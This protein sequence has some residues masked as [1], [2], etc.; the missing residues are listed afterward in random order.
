M[1]RNDDGPDSSD[2]LLDASLPEGWRH[3]LLVG[4]VADDATG[5][6]YTVT[7]SGNGG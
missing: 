5:L 2:P 6:G 1:L 4:A 3:L 7:T